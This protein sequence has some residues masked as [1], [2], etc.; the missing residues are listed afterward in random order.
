MRLVLENVDYI[1]S[2]E[3]FLASDNLTRWLKV[4]FFK[5][6][7]G[8]RVFASNNDVVIRININAYP[9]LV[10]NQNAVDGNRLRGTCAQHGAGTQ[11]DYTDNVL[12]HFL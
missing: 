6:P 1:V 4:K 8:L 9:V 3:F 2:V 10:D 5:N 12:Q 7:M 11:N